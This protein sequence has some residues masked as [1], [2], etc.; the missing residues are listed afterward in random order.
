MADT[1]AF[2]SPWFGIEFQGKITGAFRECSGLGSENE[3]VEDKAVGPDGKHRNKKIPGNLK[4]NN[5]QLKQGI[6][7]DMDMWTWRKLVEE[8]KVAEA[9]KNGSLVL[10]SHEGKEMAR[11]DFVNAWPCKI[12]GPAVNATSNEIAIE[13]LELAIEGYKRVK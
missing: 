3:V 10:F 2:L 11:W 1:D 4:I 13:E 9:R 5:I 7:D 8:G 6:T 12:T